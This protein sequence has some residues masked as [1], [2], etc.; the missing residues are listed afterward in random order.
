VARSGM[1]WFPVQTV[2][3]HRKGIVNAKY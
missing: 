1:E 2:R 3:P